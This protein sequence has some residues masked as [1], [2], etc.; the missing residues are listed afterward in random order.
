MRAKR[1]NS[2]T[3]LVEMVVYLFIFAYLSTGIYGVLLGSMRDYQMASTST[4]LQQ[5]VQS[6]TYRLAKELEETA[7]S[8]ITICAS[9][10]ACGTVGVAFESGRNAN[11]RMQIVAPVAGTYTPAA[12]VSSI[13]GIVGMPCWHQY[14]CYYLDTDQA[15]PNEKALYRKVQ[16][17]ADAWN[18]GAPGN[19][20]VYQANGGWPVITVARH[21]SNAGFSLTQSGSMY[22]LKL[23]AAHQYGNANNLTSQVYINIRQ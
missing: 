18:P 4:E 15:Q 2:G 7:P 20:S 12:C 3:S 21:L 22:L 1:S 19:P 17:H 10:G 11:G 23:T 16:S 13:G 9:G 8:S 5:A 6:A 14:V